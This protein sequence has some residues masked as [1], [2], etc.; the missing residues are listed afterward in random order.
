VTLPDGVEDSEPVATANGAPHKKL[1]WPTT[2]PT[3]TEVPFDNLSTELRM[4][5]LE[6]SGVGGM[7]QATGDIS[8]VDTRT[9]TNGA[10]HQAP[11]EEQLDAVAD[12][13]GPAE[14]S[15][16][17]AD[18]IDEAEK[19]KQEADQLISAPDPAP[20]LPMLPGDRRRAETLARNQEA[21]R[22]FEAQ[23]RRGP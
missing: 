6:L 4:M 21:L 20:A 11:T 10:Q 5:A 12:V 17:A 8:T 13:P 18:V 15:P 19:A 14:K 22:R 16:P 9:D 1:P 3:V 2:P 23:I 7:P